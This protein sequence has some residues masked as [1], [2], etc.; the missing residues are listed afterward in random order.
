MKELN[1][2]RDVNIDPDSL[3]TE[4][5][6]QPRL[7]L[8]YTRI[9]AEAK[10]DLGDAKARLDI[11]Q[12]DLDKAIRSNPDDFDLPKVTETA[13][14]NAI[15]STKKYKEAQEEI[16][17]AEYHLNMAIGAVRSM[18]VKKEAL[19]NL[20]RLYGQQYFA[21]P[22]VPR[23]INREWEKKTSQTRSNKKVK[24]KRRKKP[25]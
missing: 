23:D 22:K 10:K 19:E 17:E 2:E 14:S 20:V 9:E 7:M 3:D 11:I 4:W 21:G 15:Q 25:E 24:I 18:Y 8:K 6:D 1:Y 5:L 16:R 13:I 12:A